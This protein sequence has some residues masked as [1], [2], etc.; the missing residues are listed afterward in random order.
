MPKF[1]KFKCDILSN[2]QTMWW[3]VISSFFFLFWWTYSYCNKSS[4]NKN[5]NPNQ[6]CNQSIINWHSPSFGHNVSD[7]MYSKS[8][9]HKMICKNAGT[10]SKGQNEPLC[11]RA[12]K[13][14]PI[15]AWMNEAWFE[16][17][18]ARK[19]PAKLITCKVKTH[20]F[21]WVVICKSAFHW[22]FLHH[23]TLI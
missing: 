13:K 1:K 16:N 9:Y 20:S 15:A 4:Y 18:A 19:N 7:C 5:T 12:G 23:T 8:W 17:A 3:S 11:V 22:N 10:P 14:L 21:V 6:S 2:F